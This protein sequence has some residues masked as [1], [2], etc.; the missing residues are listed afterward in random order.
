MKKNNIILVDVD[1]VVAD[2]IHGWLSIYNKIANDNL[3]QDDIKD[4]DIGNFVKPE[5]K[6]IIY[7]IIENPNIYDVIEPVEGALSATRKLKA[8]GYRLVYVTASAITTA[9]KKF[10]WLNKHGF[11]VEL[12]DYIEAKD[13]SLIFG[14]YMIDDGAHNIESTLAPDGLLFSKPWNESYEA[15]NRVNNWD[16]ILEW[17]GVK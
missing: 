6:H 7:E 2:L 17:F 15:I 1:D 3:L 5:Y 8:A 9:G 10:Y 12:K 14:N 16:E 11:D 4:W 13:K